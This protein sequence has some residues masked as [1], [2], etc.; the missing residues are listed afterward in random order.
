M[1]RSTKQGV[2]YFPHD[3]DASE[4]KTITAM[5]VLWG[6][7]GYAFWYKLLEQLGRKSGC[8]IDCSD[9]DEWYFLLS[10]MR[11]TE[12]TA[13]AMLNKL[14]E[15]RAIDPELWREHRMIWS[16]NF[17]DRLGVL[18]KKRK[19][20][21]PVRPFSKQPEAEMPIMMAKKP[22]SDTE[23]RISAAEKPISDA[24]KSKYS[25]EV[26]DE[27]VH[28][29]RQRLDAI[30]TTAEKFG[31]SVFDGDLEKAER[32]AT[33]YS[34]EWLLKAIETGAGGKERTWR[35]VE[36]ILKN[37]KK[38]GTTEDVRKPKPGDPPKQY[39]PDALDQWGGSL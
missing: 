35:Y 39:E 30:I 8:C 25:F 14:A 20:G 7:D 13:T 33:D 2:D 24:E 10:K 4:R 3:T 21:S 1:G 28:Q 38:N 17:V 26:S 22:V 11:V 5:E 23:K 34:L 31:L 15:L 6:N 29:Y 32:L 18:F 37:W 16:Q 12:D 27:E 9:L 36:G 19:E